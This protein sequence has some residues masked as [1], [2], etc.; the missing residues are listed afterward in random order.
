M[1]AL[2]IRVVSMLVGIND[3]H[4]EE[5]GVA[6]AHSSRSFCIVPFAYYHRLAMLAHTISVLTFLALPL[7]IFALA[8]PSL[9]PLALPAGS[10]ETNATAIQTAPMS[11][12]MTSIN[13][14]TCASASPS[15]VCCDLLVTVSIPD[16]RNIYG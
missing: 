3:E 14:T 1:S 4:C 8:P 13:G 10:N 2:V 11:S 15:P 12:N 5:N 6:G 16:I 9:V 7:H